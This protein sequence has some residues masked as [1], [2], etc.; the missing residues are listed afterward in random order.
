MS[1]DKLT[2]KFVE[3]VGALQGPGLD[4]AREAARTEAYS[5]L[6]LDIVLTV[7]GVWLASKGHK[8][9]LADKDIDSGITL[10]WMIGGGIGAFIG[11]LGVVSLLDPWLWMTML[12]PEQWLAKKAL[13][14]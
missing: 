4:I 2:D 9:W 5:C 14:L 7:A 8:A 10:A 13:G 12:Y 1:I 3:I 11:F 6:R